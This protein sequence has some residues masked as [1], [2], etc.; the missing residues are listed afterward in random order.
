MEK[1]G[2]AR[3]GKGMAWLNRT[4]WTSLEDSGT[5]ETNCILLSQKHRSV[6]DI[7]FLR[8]TICTHLYSHGKTQH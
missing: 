8:A 4:D 5:S 6:V 2:L 7:I 3:G 1:D